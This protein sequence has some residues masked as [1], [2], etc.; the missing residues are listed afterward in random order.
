MLKRDAIK[1]LL[2]NEMQ[3]GI[4]K[5]KDRKNNVLPDLALLKTTDESKWW[6]DSCPVCNDTFREHDLV[7]T[8]PKCKQA[9][10]DDASF[11][12]RCWNKHFTSGSNTCINCGV[13]KWDGSLPEKEFFHQGTISAFPVME[14]Q[15]FAGLGSTWKTFGDAKIHIVT[16]GDFR[17]G[18]TCLH[19]R[20]KIRLGDRLVKCPCSSKCLVHFHHD[21]LKNRT[22]WNEYHGK[23]GKNYCPESSKPYPVKKIFT[24]I[25]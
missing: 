19:C 13:F 1:L 21:V 2:R 18:K 5:A 4:K 25:S 3:L 7:R 17:I 11:D 10:H 9:Y 6:G 14:V 8:C 15:F 12:L 22:C 24:K 20:Q 16:A 23:D